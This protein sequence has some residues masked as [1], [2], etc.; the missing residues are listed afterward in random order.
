MSWLGRF[1]QGDIVPIAFTTVDNVGTAALP[2]DSP[3]AIIYKGASVL[4]NKLIP[5]KDRYEI[6]AF[7]FYPLFL[8][9][10]FGA[11]QYRII[12]NWIIGSTAY[13]D[14]KTFQVLASGHRDGQAIALAGVTFPAVSYA[15]I[16]TTAGRI[17]KRRNPRAL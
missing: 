16:H 6:T 13:S 11:D 5:N 8:D 9:A 3:S 7:F 2:A 4:T 1:Q 15:L 14:T 17:I 10:R 12:L